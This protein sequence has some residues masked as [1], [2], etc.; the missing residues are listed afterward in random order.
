VFFPLYLII[1]LFTQYCSGDQIEKNEVGGVCSAYEGRE[2]VHRDFW[3]L[4]L[5]ERDHL[6]DPDI[7]GNTILKWIFRKWDVGQ[8]LGLC[9]SG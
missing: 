2:E 5:R 1:C 7:D 6:E 4:N 8:G 3:W 9:V